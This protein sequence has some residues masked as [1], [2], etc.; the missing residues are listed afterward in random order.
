[1]NLMCVVLHQKHEKKSTKVSFWSVLLKMLL[2]MLL[3]EMV[4]LVLKQRIKHL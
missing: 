3:D 1:M 2:L 4:A